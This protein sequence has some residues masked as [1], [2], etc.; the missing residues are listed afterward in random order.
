MYEKSYSSVFPLSLDAPLISEDAVRSYHNA[1]WEQQWQKWW[2]RVIWIQQKQ[3]G[4]GLPLALETGSPGNASPPLPI[5]SP[6]YTGEDLEVEQVSQAMNLP[7]NNCQVPCLTDMKPPLLWSACAAA[8]AG[9]GEVWAALVHQGRIL[10]R[11]LAWVSRVS[12]GAS[13]DGEH[14]WFFWLGVGEGPM[15]LHSQ[16]AWLKGTA[17]SLEGL[18]VAAL[19]NKEG[20][21]VVVFPYAR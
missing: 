19:I 2:H 9:S 21:T 14:H 4:M 12:R 3:A 16:G 11:G 10:S 7:F 8:A 13:G 1:V 6:V 17:V 15:E 20:D 5:W 18:D